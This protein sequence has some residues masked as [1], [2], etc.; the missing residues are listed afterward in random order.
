MSFGVTIGTV[1]FDPLHQ[2]DDE[3]GDGLSWIVQFENA[4]TAE[5]V[6]RLRKEFALRLTDF[7]PALAYV[8]RVP[9]TTAKALRADPLVRAV[10][11]YQ[12]EMKIAAAAVEIGKR[13][14]QDN[15]PNPIR[16]SAVL[17]DDGAVDA[18]VQALAKI[19]ATDVTVLDDRTMHGAAIVRFRIVNVDELAAISQVSDVRWIEPVPEAVDDAVGDGA[20]TAPG[21]TVLGPLWAVGLH[22]EGQ[23]ISILDSGPPDIR[24][25]YFKDDSDNTP[26]PAHRKVVAIR[27]AS[28]SDAGAHPTF[29]AGCLA[30]DDFQSPGQST[31]RGGAWAARLFCGNRLDLDGGS[32]LLAELTAAM[33]GGA[34]IHSNSWHVEPQGVP[35][36]RNPS[37]YDVTCAQAD[38][39]AWS[40]EEHLVLGSSGNTGETQGPPGT[41]KNTLS[42]S[43]A[44]ADA[45]A[46]GDG[47]SGPTQD[48]RRKPDA[49]MIG[50]GLQSATI[51]TNCATGPRST[52]AS[53]FA[54][55]WAAAAAAL[56]RQYFVEGRYPTNSA[57]H[58]VLAPTGA[59]LK[60]SS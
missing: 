20:S 26:G 58:K 21:A 33:A 1:Q 28:N 49:M 56:V 5:D 22:G 42:V 40:N 41:A 60:R 43:A 34:T 29:V 52:C 4:L 12:P 37:A 38:Q 24:H 23:I 45:I 8:E 9:E 32:T 55:P 19:G 13:S 2:K 46:L 15:E 50:C 30:G 36:N 44:R 59:L 10:A 17:F 57:S 11:A 3:P 7:V 31:N 14:K 39:F 47:C 18:V 27:N 51:N 25:C 53:S 48:G 54:T 6:A 35:G 16:F